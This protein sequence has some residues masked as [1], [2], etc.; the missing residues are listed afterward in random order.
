MLPMN[1]VSAVIYGMPCSTLSLSLTVES[2]MDFH[3][4]PTGKT[5][6][7]QFKEVIKTVHNQY[8]SLDGPWRGFS[9]S[10]SPHPA[11][12][13]ALCLPAF[14]HWQLF[15]SS[16]QQEPGTSC[17]HSRLKWH[18]SWI[19]KWSVSRCKNMLRKFV[20]QQ[21]PRANGRLA[22]NC[23]FSAIANHHFQKQSIH[24]FLT[25]WI[26]WNFQ[27]SWII[28]KMSTPGFVFFLATA[29]ITLTLSNHLC[30][31]GRSRE[32]RFLDVIW[33]FIRML[34]IFILNLNEPK[35][36]WI[37]KNSGNVICQRQLGRTEYPAH[38]RGN[39]STKGI[40]CTNLTVIKGH[41]RT[42]PIKRT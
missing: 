27:N 10:P 17:S 39:K 18:V 19:I 35:T 14:S 4:E 20:P 31:S 16:V 9:A 23:A 2:Y 6:I 12:R 21:S 37:Q 7:A 34:N 38:D 1:Y 28:K 5:K 3:R 25:L 40:T 26:L 36:L 41:E 15:G 24:R 30:T 33:I 32:P 29:I 8:L 11:S 13:L 42:L 22:R